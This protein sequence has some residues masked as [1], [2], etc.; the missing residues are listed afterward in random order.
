MGWGRVFRL[1]P[2]PRV[3]HD[4]VTVTGTEPAFAKNER[5]RSPFRKSDPGDGMIH[6]SRPAHIPNELAPCLRPS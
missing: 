2:G 3:E 1:S 6:C 4:L 5:K